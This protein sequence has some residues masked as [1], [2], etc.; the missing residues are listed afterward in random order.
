MTPFAACLI[1]TL[2]VAATPVSAES[3]RETLGAASAR[4]LVDQCLDVSQATHPP[5]NAD[6][7]CDLITD[8]IRRG[9]QGMRDDAPRYCE[10]Y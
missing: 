7:A 1:L 8:E 4:R 5:C 6:N 10:Q 2:A 3:C 9:C